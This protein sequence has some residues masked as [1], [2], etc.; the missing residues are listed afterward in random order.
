M[1]RS[2]MIQEIERIERRRESRRRLDS[3]RDTLLRVGAVL[4]W[5]GVFVL[6]ASLDWI[7]CGGPCK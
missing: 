4:A 2:P 7:F 3:L 5:V 6:V 1:D